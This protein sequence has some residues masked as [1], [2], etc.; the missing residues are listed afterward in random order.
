MQAMRLR[1]GEQ[2]DRGR[3]PV[4]WQSEE[5]STRTPAPE[6]A[7]QVVDLLADFEELLLDSSR[8]DW[9]VPFPEGLLG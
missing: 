6:V 2:V 3:F 1:S 7:A 8:E 9:L 5:I 4:I